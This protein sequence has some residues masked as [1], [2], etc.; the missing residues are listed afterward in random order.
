MVKEKGDNVAPPHPGYILLLEAMQPLGISRNQLARDLDVPVGRIS[1]IT[2][3]KRGITADTA[4]RLGRYFGTNPDIWMRLQ[5]EYDLHV[6]NNTA[7]AEII[8][9]VRRLKTV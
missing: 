3:G 8:E 2:N 6:A 7:G 1:E 5:A 9:R 4:L